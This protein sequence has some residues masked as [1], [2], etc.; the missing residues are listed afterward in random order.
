[1]FS[2]FLFFFSKKA[3]TKKF[4]LH[5]LENRPCALS[6]SLRAQASSTLIRVGWLGGTGG[7]AHQTMTA[8]WTYPYL[9][10]DPKATS[11]CWIFSSLKIAVACGKRYILIKINNK[12]A[13]INVDRIIL[14]NAVRLFVDCVYMWQIKTKNEYV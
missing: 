6:H 13:A 2:V 9:P 12:Q 3:K 8:G 10:A 1:M 7:G 5:T 4:H 14:H 11:C